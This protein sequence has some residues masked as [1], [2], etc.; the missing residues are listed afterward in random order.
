MPAPNR[1]QMNGYFRT[2]LT[3]HIGKRVELLSAKYG[4]IQLD[5][6][7]I[8]IGSPIEVEGHREWSD[9]SVDALLD[10]L[11]LGVAQGA[12]TQWPIS[13]TEV[14]NW[15]DTDSVLGPWVRANL[16]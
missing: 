13:V 2:A 11:Q 3:N 8:L 9:I 15:C 1:T 16:P 14:K 12:I 6:D 5:G 4:T 10:F 7:T